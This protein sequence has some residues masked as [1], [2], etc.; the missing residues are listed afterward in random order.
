MKWASDLLHGQIMHVVDEYNILGYSV[1][2]CMYL[3]QCTFNGT[4]ISETQTRA[5][6]DL[7]LIHIHCLHNAS[8]SNWLISF[9]NFLNETEYDLQTQRKDNSCNEGGSRNIKDYYHPDML[10]DPWKF[11]SPVPVTKP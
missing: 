9:H 10:Q 8:S 1:C 5:I 11:C 3:I 4:G 2:V 7:I 6:I